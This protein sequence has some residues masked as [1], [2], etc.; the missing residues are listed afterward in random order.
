MPWVNKYKLETQHELAVHKNK[1]AEVDT[2]LKAEG[3]GK[4]TKT[5]WVYFIS[6]GLLDV[7]KQL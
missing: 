2:W 4:A 5:G 3:L 1:I 7:E 6:N